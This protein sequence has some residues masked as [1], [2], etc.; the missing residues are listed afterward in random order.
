MLYFIPTPI[1]NLSD[2]SFRALELLKTCN[3]VFCEDTR[4]SKSLIS[5]LNA[6]FHTDIHISK[7][8]ALHSHNEKEVLASIDLKIFEKNVAYLSDAGMPGIS[9]PGRTLVEFA[10]ENNITYEILPGANAALVALVSSAF[11]Q[12]EFIFIGFLANKGNERQKD[13]EKILNLPYPSIIYESPK[14][15]LSLVEQIMILDNQREIFLIKE[16]SKKFEKKFKGNAKELFEILK[17][18]NLNGEWVVVLQSKEQNFLQNTLCEKDIMDLELPLKAKA[19]LLS[20][21]NGKNAKEIYQKL[22]LSQN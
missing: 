16:I 9:D 8:I 19:K 15:I 7:F 2:I 6:K 5:L 21:F 11:C 14:R 22:L 3:L 18:S 4:V 10:Q 17:K 1:G 20:K 13:I 12:K